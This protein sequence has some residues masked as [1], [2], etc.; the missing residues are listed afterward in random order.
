MKVSQLSQH[1][2]SA[3]NLLTDSPYLKCDST[4]TGATASSSLGYPENQVIN[5]WVVNYNF[6]YCSEIT[7]DVIAENNLKPRLVLTISVP[8]SGGF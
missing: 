5:L 4:I 2:E 3:L 1:T 6:L 7:A 8:T